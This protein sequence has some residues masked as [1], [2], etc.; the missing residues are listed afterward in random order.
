[1]ALAFPL[2]VELPDGPTKKFSLPPLVLPMLLNWAAGNAPSRLLAVL[3]FSAR[4][5]WWKAPCGPVGAGASKGSGRISFREIAASASLRSHASSAPTGRARKVGLEHVAKE[6]LV[7][8]TFA[9][10]P[11]HQ[12]WIADLFAPLNRSP[13]IVE[14][15]DSITSL[16]AA[17]ESGRGVAAIAQPLNGLASPRLKIRPLQPAPPPVGVGIVYCKKFRSAATDKFIAAARQAKA[18]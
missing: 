13:Q 7:A 3:A 6:R 1:M 9:D 15:H 17:V 16:I 8:F 4:T 12:A 11:E 10:Y 18:T 14:E 5:E 2:I